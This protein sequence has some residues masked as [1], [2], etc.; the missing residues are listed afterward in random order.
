MLRLPLLR[1]LVSFLDLTES[2]MFLDFMADFTPHSPQVDSI[3]ESETI[4]TDTHEWLDASGS[5][6]E[7][8]RTASRPTRCPS[9]LKGASKNAHQIEQDHFSLPTRSI[10]LLSHDIYN[11]KMTK[12][13]HLHFEPVTTSSSFE[14]ISEVEFFVLLFCLKYMYVILLFY[15]VFIFKARARTASCFLS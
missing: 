7:V 2:H 14:W 13:D 8:V 4:N 15:V 11:Y 12:H 6:M 9:K 1:V 3:D 10:R 5:L